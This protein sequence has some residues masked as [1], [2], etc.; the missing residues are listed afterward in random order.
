MGIGIVVIAAVAA[1]ILLFKAC[2]RVAEPNEALVISGFSGKKMPDSNDESMRFQIVTGAGTLV[3]PGVQVVRKLSL[4]LIETN[5]SIDCVT[6][7]GIPVEIEGSVIFK[8]GDTYPEI[9][10]AARR[11]L[12]KP[13]DV[14]LGKVHSIFAGHLRAIVGN[15]TLESLLS[16]R[17]ELRDNVRSASGTEMAALG[18]KIDSM[19]LLQIVDPTNYIANIRAPYVAA[20][21]AL[22]RTARA[23]QDQAAT[24]KEQTA[25]IAMAVAKTTAARRQAELNAEAQTAQATAAQAGPL[26]DATARQKVVEAATRTAELEANK[27]AMELEAQVR[28]PADA[29]AYQIKVTAE[30]DRDAAI[31]A[32]E[33]K[34]KTQTLSA[35]ANATTTKLNA[36]ADAE[37]T[38]IRGEAQASAIQA[39]GLAEASAT[40]A[41]GLAEAEAAKAK[42]LAEAMGMDARADA[43]NK[44]QDALIAQMVAERLPEIAGN[45][46]SPLGN[47]KVTIL[48]GAE[49]WAQTVSASIA[50]LGDILPQLLGTVQSL[51]G[52]LG[53]TTETTPEK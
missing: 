35:E 36:V 15:M 21:E 24:E 31:A 28:R 9:A 17:D 41:K 16:D 37:S 48:N 27:T 1:L 5:L 26:A 22:A 49:G 39:T 50:T 6:K 53:S 51:K 20:A 7:Q 29:N 4:S 13:E 10:N 46:A 34:A 40:Q 33:A 38:R 43:L 18:L 42:G 32:A 2:W 45:L 23:Q 12:G 14:M 47:A 19:Q 8:V 11:F 25:A 44:G 52:S 3:L 30:A